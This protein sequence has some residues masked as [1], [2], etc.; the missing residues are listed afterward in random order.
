MYKDHRTSEIKSC[1]KGRCIKLDDKELK[2]QVARYWD[3][4]SKD[5][6]SHD[7]H[8]L[9]GE[10]EKELWMKFLSQIIPL[11][12]KDILDVGCGTGFLTLLLAEQGYNVKGIDLSE[13]M[14]ADAKKKVAESGFED[15]VSFEIGDAE[16]TREPDNKYDVVI[17]RHLLWTLP[18]PYEAI[19]EWLRVTKPGGSVIIIDGDWYNICPCMRK[20][21]RPTDDG[22][23]DHSSDNSYSE[24]LI[25][26]LPLH[27]G[28]GRPFD[29]VNRKGYEITIVSLEDID[30]FERIKYVNNEFLSSEKYKREAYIIKKPE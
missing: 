24:E 26:R 9:K 16:K 25:D 1:R 13:G 30:S 28:K 10:D 5:Y 8:G 18:H 20:E 17:N 23:Y 12:T 7:G 27:S 14:Q 19:D 22:R 21:N 4:G 29:Y 15:R 6:D 2:E 3:Q 11:G